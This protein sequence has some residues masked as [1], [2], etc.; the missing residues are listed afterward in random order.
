MLVRQ[1]VQLFSQYLVERRSNQHICPLVIR[2]CATASQPSKQQTDEVDAAIL[3][4][5]NARR[6]AWDRAYISKCQKQ[7]PK[8]VYVH[9][10]FWPLV[11]RIGF[12]RKLGLKLEDTLRARM[13]VQD[14]IRR[15]PKEEREARANRLQ[16]AVMLHLQRRILPKEEWTTEM[17]L[18]D[19]WKALLFCIEEEYVFRQHT[20]GKRKFEPFLSSVFRVHWPKRIFKQSQYS[21]W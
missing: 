13:P 14:V 1:Q 7:Y 16:R 17:E 18:P 9:G 15:L 2:Q 8:N 20:N 10:D 21:W 19:R 5:V 6:T 4:I 3:E 11:K 12:Y